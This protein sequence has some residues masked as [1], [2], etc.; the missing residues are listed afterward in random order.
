MEVSIHICSC[1][2]FQQYIIWG[3]GHKRFFVKVS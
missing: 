1:L 2:M 3:T